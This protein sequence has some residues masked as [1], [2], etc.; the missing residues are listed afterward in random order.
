MP[1]SATIETQLTAGENEMSRDDLVI[2]Y[3][4]LVRYVLGRFAIYVPPQ[5]DQDDLIEAGVV[6]LIDAAAKF[7]PSRGTLFKTYAVTRIR[8]AILD[9]L[10]SHDTLSRSARRKAAQITA[11]FNQLSD[12]LDRPPTEDE[13]AAELGM[14]RQEYV[15][16]RSDVQLAPLVSLSGHESDDES[17]NSQAMAD[18]LRNPAAEDPADVF[19]RE[20]EKELLTEAIKQ[21]TVQ[22]RTVVTLYYYEEML[23]REIG[24]LLDVTESRV[25]QILTKSIML[26]EAKLRR[27]HQ[28]CAA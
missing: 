25:S 21:L 14:T 23:L 22:E 27:A 20:E 7:D 10:R 6:G 13:V 9:E 15:K 17:D 18:V 12:R 28:P 3:L 24:E 4:P 16:A 1:N 5:I 2:K 11:T 8:G 26:L 19:A